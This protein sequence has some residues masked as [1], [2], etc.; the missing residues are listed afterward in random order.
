MLMQMFIGVLIKT[1]LFFLEIFYFFMKY[2]YMR[3]CEFVIDDPQC[4]Q[5]KNIP[6]VDET[7][8]P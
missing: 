6:I 2:V 5:N 7:Y 1:N 4:V 3:G 8:E